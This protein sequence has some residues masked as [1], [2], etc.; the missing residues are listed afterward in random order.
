VG[1][2][3]ESVDDDNIESEQDEVW[4]EMDEHYKRSAKT[5]FD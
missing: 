2:D 3:K 5:T 4:C 1:D